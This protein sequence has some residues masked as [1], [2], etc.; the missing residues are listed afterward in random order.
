[1]AQ[2]DDQPPA[3]IQEALDVIKRIAR[4]LPTM[5]VPLAAALGLTLAEN[6][7]TDID[8]PP[9]DKTMMDGFAVQAASCR[10]EG[11]TWRIA[12]ELGAGQVWFHAVQPDEAVRI[13]TGAP[14]PSG[15]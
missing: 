6:I 4:P 14:M 1:M 8:S 11:S 2:M 5:R 13:N 10:G 15:T 7:V 12:G 3:T 9:F